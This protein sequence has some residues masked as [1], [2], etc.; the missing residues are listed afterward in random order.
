VPIDNQAPAVSVLAPNGGE[1]LVVGSTFTITWTATDNTGVANV[2]LAYS[3]DGGA[4]YPNVIATGI[5]NS[6]SFAWTVPNTPNTT[7]RVRVSAHDVVCSSA[8]DASDANFTIRDPIITASAGPGGS[9]SPT[10]AVP[11]P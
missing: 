9:I 6:G 8:S 10:G 4:T 11:V 5:A 3:T 1:S 2:D 7:A